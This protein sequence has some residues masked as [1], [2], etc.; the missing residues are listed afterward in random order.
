[1]SEESPRS[2]KNDKKAEYG[3]RPTS[4]ASLSRALSQTH[5]SISDMFANES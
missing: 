2:R 1:M 5:E 4:D 3:K